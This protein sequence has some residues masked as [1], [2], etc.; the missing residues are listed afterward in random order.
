MVKFK[1]MVDYVVAMVPIILVM[2][3]VVLPPVGEEYWCIQ[4]VLL[5]RIY[6]YLDAVLVEV[7]YFLALGDLQ[8]ESFRKRMH[9]GGW[10][11]VAGGSHLEAL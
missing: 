3:W 7:Y 6:C 8:R 5:N 2:I 11:L 1:V 4:M 10:D 9:S